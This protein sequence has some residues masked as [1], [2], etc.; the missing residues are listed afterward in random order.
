MA[1]C[2]SALA[3]AFGGAA[4]AS[5]AEGLILFAQPPDLLVRSGERLTERGMIRQRLHTHA[6]LLLHHCRLLR[7][8]AHLLLRQLSHL[9]ELDGQTRAVLPSD[10]L[11]AAARSSA[12]RRSSDTLRVR[13]ICDC[14]ARAASP[15][16]LDHSTQL[17]EHPVA[18]GDA[19][20]E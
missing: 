16:S 15:E 8:R 9:G 14:G 17:L 12:A 20:P 13:D 7:L 1:S 19:L 11:C 18:L 6:R 2:P 3:A 4:L 10:S 5:L